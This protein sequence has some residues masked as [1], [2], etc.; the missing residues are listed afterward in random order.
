MNRSQKLYCTDILDRIQRIEAYASAGRDAFVE[1][2]IH[3]DAV[4]YCF[5]IIGEAIKNLNDELITKHPKIDWRGFA[6]FRDILV[7]RYH[8]IEIEVAWLAVQ[9][10]LPL[11]KTAIMEMLTFLDD[12]GEQS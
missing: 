8:N 12:S 9:E 3:Q 10:D 6:R 11:L 7:H 4:I 1:S 2:K 5:T